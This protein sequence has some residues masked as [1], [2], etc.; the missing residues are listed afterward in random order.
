MS[1]GMILYKITTA[2]SLQDWKHG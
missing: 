2:F 1:I